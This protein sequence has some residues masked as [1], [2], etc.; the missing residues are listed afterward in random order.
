MRVSA[1]PSWASIPKQL[2]CSR[3]SWLK[4]LFG[5]S[6]PYLIKGSEFAATIGILDITT[7]AQQKWLGFFA[8]G[9]L[10]QQTVK[11]Q[12]KQRDRGESAKKNSHTTA[13]ELNHQGAST[14]PTIA[15]RGVK[16]H[17]PI[18]KT[19]NCE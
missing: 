17:T 9:M 13:R 18:C 6:Q 19:L 1:C 12:E 8:G 2:I 10:A 15:M 7:L 16:P 4:S 5:D 11:G 3:P 14:K